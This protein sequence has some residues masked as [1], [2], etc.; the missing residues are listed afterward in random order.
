MVMAAFALFPQDSRGRVQGV[1]TDTSGAQVVGS[2]V[3]L[4]NVP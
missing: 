3:T 2:S 1:V 4:R